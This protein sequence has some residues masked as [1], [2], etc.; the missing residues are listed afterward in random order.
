MTARPRPSPSC[1]YIASA[2]SSAARA[3]VRSPWSQASRPTAASAHAR[4]LLGVSSPCAIA[5]SSHARPSLR[6]PWTYQ[7][8]QSAPANRCAASPSRRIDAHA[9]AA[10]RLSCSASSRSSQTRLLGAGQLAAR[11]SPRARGSARRGHPGQLRLA[12]AGRLQLLGGELADRLQHREARRRP[13]RSP[14]A[15]PGCGRPAPP[16]PRTGRARRPGRPPPPPP[17][18]RSRRRRPTSRAKSACSAGGEQVV[19]PGDRAAQRL[20]PRRRGRAPPPVSSAEP[21]AP[22]A[23]SSAGGRQQLD[24]RRRQLDRQRQPVQPPADL[25]HRRRRSRRSARSPALA[26]CARSTKSSH[27]RVLAPARAGRRQPPRVG[28]RQR[29][30]RELALAAD[31]AAAPGW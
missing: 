3:G 21:V 20:L 22:G 25:G 16:A 31:A 30:H 18:G 4:A 10:R 12:A 14:P 8:R 11:P 5:R 15:G 6:W 13:P 2:R 27:R 28:Q 17:P 9:R 23:R 1:W 24:P 19:A 7:K 29:R 26:A